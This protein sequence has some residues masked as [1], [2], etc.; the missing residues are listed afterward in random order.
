[1]SRQ[2]LLEAQLAE[3]ANRPWELAIAIISGTPRSTSRP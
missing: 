2:T 3:I 1:M